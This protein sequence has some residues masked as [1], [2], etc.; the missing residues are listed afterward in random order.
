MIRPSAIARA[1]RKAPTAETYIA[2]GYDED[3]AANFAQPYVR[4]MGHHFIPRDFV[5]PD[6]VMGVPLPRQLVGQPLPRWYSESEFNVLK[7]RGLT[8]GEMAELHYRV[9]PRYHGNGR[10]KTRW[11]GEDLGWEKYGLAGRL[12]HGSPGPLKDAVWMAGALPTSL[13]HHLAQEDDEE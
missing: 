9:D 8:K 11:S 13:A 6:R 10:G 3:L 7:P 2:R 1:S 12:W 4:G 5:L